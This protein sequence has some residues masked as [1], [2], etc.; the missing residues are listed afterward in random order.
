MQSASPSPLGFFSDMGF[1]QNTLNCLHA[2]AMQEHYDDMPL[3]EGLLKKL[4]FQ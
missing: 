3:V 1:I 2:I 4:I